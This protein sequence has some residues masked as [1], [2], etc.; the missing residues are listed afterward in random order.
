MIKGYRLISTAILLSVLC[1]LHLQAQIKTDARALGLAGAY[2][3]ISR[4]M[5]AVGWNPAN[6][7]FRDEGHTMVSLGKMYFKVDNSTLSISNLN[8]YNGIDLE[9]LNPYTNRI[10]KE[11]F[12][13]LFPDQGMNFYAHGDLSLPLMSF[14]R[15][16]I[17]YTNDVAFSGDFNMPNS[18]IEIMFVGNTVDKNYDMTF[19]MEL[20]ALMAH[21][22]SIAFPHEFGS[23]GFTVSYLQGLTYLGLDPD[24]SDSWFV[25]DTS[26][27][28][29]HGEYVT[30][31]TVGGNGVG[32]DIGYT[33]RE[34][35]GWQFSMAVN[36]LFANIVWNKETYTYRLLT[37]VLGVNSSPRAAYRRHWYDISELRPTD[38]LDTG[39][40]SDSSAAE[41][42]GI[43]LFSSGDS[44]ISA[45]DESFS[46]KYPA[47]FRAGLLRRLNDEVTLVL[48]VSTGFEDRF[49]AL[50]V[51]IWSGGLEIVRTPAFPIRV[52]LAFGSAG[53]RRMA[54]GFSL[55]KSIFSLDFGMAFNGGFTASSAKGVEIALGGHLRFQ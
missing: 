19:E 36:N 24:S 25:T 48:D 6:L 55:R 35:D 20:L 17:A 40:T 9:E 3:T 1:S 12:L 21:R 50:P 14:S 54:Y 38:L 29:A 23:L 45:A 39:G 27:V 44:A 41:S 52:G 18:L 37:D 46:V 26:I 4:G 22:F 11:E 5:H 16:N 31:R 13:E 51:W 34:F 47:V 7:A 15:N 28:K 53:Y 33:T 42:E 8:K 10:Y 2:S 43:E 30:R 49:Y 32:L